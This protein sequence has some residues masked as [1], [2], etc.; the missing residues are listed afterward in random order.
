[1]TQKK[2]M[3]WPGYIPYRLTY[4]QVI[5]LQRLPGRGQE[6]KLYYKSNNPATS[7]PLNLLNVQPDRRGGEEK[8]P[9]PEASWARVQFLTPHHPFSNPLTPCSFQPFPRRQP[10]PSPA[11]LLPA[12]P[13]TPLPAWRSPFPPYSSDPCHAPQVSPKHHHLAP[14][15]AS[16]ACPSVP[17]FTRLLLKT[18]LSCCGHLNP[19]LLSTSSL[20][21]HA[22]RDPKPTQKAALTKICMQRILEQKSMRFQEEKKT[23]KTKNLFPVFIWIIFKLLIKERWG[24]ARLY[25]RQRQLMRN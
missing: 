19:P 12:G 2:Y 24:K 4:V 13:G 7:P 5:Y 20:G 18:L 23:S 9:H 15:P 11:Q 14:P 3:S 22:K 17:S 21:S 25:F 1:M 8:P 10:G 16:P 6:T